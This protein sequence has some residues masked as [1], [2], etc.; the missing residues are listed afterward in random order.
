MYKN[1][2]K[3]SNCGLLEGMISCHHSKFVYSAD[4]NF[5]GC[6]VDQSHNKE[7]GL[8]VLQHKAAIMF[9]E[10]SLKPPKQVVF[11]VTYYVLNFC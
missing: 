5:L 10:D 9:A 8:L 11:Q 6:H 3:I 7:E 4:G 1:L 2:I